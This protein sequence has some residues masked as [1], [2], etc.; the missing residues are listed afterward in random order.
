MAL[1][2]LHQPLCAHHQ[3]GLDGG[4]Q[5]V[6][7]SPPRARS[8]KRK[9][10]KEIPNLFDYKYHRMFDYEPLPADEAERGTIGIPRVLNMYENFPFW[11]TFLKELKFRVILSPQSTR[12]IYELGIESIPSESE[13]Y[14]AKLVHGHISWLIRQGVR[15]IFYP[16]IPYERNETRRQATTTTARWSPLAAENIKNN[17]EELTEFDVH[18]MNP[19]FA[20]TNEEVLTKQLIVEFGKEY[21]LS[22]CRRQHTLHGRS[23]WH[24]AATWRKRRGNH[25]LVKGA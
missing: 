15:D 19:F 22:K 8:W 20:F 3:P 18:F 9:G 4:R 12:K 17:V 11:A 2:G 6:S 23:F 25:R 21:L 14:P 7:G 13:C 24:P 5:F 1:Q 10:Q 16:C